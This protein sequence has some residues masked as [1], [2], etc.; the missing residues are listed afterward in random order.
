[1]A[2]LFV[3]VKLKR[4]QYRTFLVTLGN[5]ARWD[6]I[7][8]FHSLPIGVSRLRSNCALLVYG[9]GKSFVKYFAAFLS[10]FSDMI[11]WALPKSARD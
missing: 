7:R 3:S 2:Q 8:V 4:S 9:Y 6:A 1:M 5:V 10:R 11:T